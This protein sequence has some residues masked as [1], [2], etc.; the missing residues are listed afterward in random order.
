V[1]VAVHE[2]GVTPGWNND[3]DPGAHDVSTG[4]VPPAAVGAGH[5]IAT[6]WFWIEN[7]D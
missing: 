6:G 3:P 4:S 7:P 2:T 1:S 5:E